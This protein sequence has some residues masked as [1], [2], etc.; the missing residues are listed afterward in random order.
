[1]ATDERVAKL[2]ANL[3]PGQLAKLVVDADDRIAEL[4]GVRTRD[5]L[6]F[7]RVSEQNRSRC[8]R[9]HPPGNT[10]LSV[11]TSNAMCG[12]IG[13]AANVVKKL[14]RHATGTAGPGEESVEALCW[15]LALEL[16]DGFLYMDLLAADYELDL[17]AAII[18]KFNAVSVLKG[19]P[20]RL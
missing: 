18:H 5:G 13:E 9:M 17:V 14:R 7:Q 12:E 1:M 19:L 20:E 8:K 15:K 11:D 4:M 16:A 10:W 2:V 6:T 3:T